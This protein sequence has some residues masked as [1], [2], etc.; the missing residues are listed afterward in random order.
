[1]LSVADADGKMSV[2]V[3]VVVEERERMR[4]AM[5][6]SLNLAGAAVRRVKPSWLWH[7]QVLGASG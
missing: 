1:M 4:L 6:E 3:G 7:L 5:G 2:E